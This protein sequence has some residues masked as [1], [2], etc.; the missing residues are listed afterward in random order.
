M[1]Y[2]QKMTDTEGTLVDFGDMKAL[3]HIHVPYI[4]TG[5]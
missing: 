3:M 5:K 4:Y 2:V 1:S